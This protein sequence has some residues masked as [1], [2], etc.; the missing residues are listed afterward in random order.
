MGLEILTLLVP[1]W[2]M[3]HFQLH[4]LNRGNTCAPIRVQFVDQQNCTMNTVGR[5]HDSADANTPCTHRSVAGVLLNF[6]VDFLGFDF[7]SGFGRGC[8]GDCGCDRAGIFV[9][10]RR[11]HTALCKIQLY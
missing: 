2:L 3:L 7:D 8:G 1:T 11:R 5:G 10:C 9:C 6:Q 4:T